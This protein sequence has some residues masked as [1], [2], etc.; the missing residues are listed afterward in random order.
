[1]LVPLV[2]VVLVAT[3]FAQLAEAQWVDGYTVVPPAQM[4]VS[5]YAYP[6]DYSANYLSAY[7]Y[8]VSYVSNFPSIPMV[9]VSVARSDACQP[10]YSIANG[11]ANGPVR[12]PA[13]NSGA[14]GSGLAA[15]P[16]D[17][18]RSSGWRPTLNAARQEIS[19]TS[20]NR[21]TYELT[22]EEERWLDRMNRRKSPEAGQKFTRLWATMSHDERQKFY[23]EIQRAEAEASA[24]SI[25]EL[26]A[27]EKRWHESFQKLTDTWSKMSLD[28][29]RKL[30]ADLKHSESQE[31]KQKAAALPSDTNEKPDE[32]KPS[33]EAQP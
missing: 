20:P 19:P 9:Q 4:C 3:G 11:S 16:N 17:S 24:A 5:G 10:N 26:P 28:E 32:K 30:Y 8:P 25:A 1:M 31:A 7:S 14:A 2:V 18:T 6:V 27:D 29:R 21:R 13:A 33:P 22:Q 23:A 12:S 15:K